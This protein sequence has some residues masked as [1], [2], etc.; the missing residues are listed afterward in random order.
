MSIFMDY[1][2]SGACIKNNVA[3]NGGCN[4]DQAFEWSEVNKL[5]INASR[6]E[7]IVISLGNEPDIQ[8]RILNGTTTEQR[9]Q[10]YTCIFSNINDIF[11]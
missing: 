6:I 3:P 9:D 7:H 11:W 8:P 2:I 10:K 5:G 4:T 1:T